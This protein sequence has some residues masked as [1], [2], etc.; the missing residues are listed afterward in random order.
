MTRIGHDCHDFAT[1][2][3]LLNELRLKS[4]DLL[5]L[6]WRTRDVGGSEL[7]TWLRD[8]FGNRIPLLL[9]ATE[10]DKPAL[11]RSL[12]NGAD[13]FLLRPLCRIELQARVQALL[14]RAYPMRF[15]KTLDCGP[16]HF[17]PL[18]RTLLLRGKAIKLK[19]REYDLALYLCRNAG[20]LMTRENLIHTVWGQDVEDH[21]R[22]IDTH[23]SR[24]R[25]RMDLCPENGVVLTSVYGLGYR[26]EVCS[27][28]EHNDSPYPTA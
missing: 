9:V 11:L 15:E 27:Q 17:D 12:V 2:E 19:H 14:R 25:T 8:R 22:S 28:A 26:L 20:R 21:S 3:S 5:L 13:D 4:Y 18:T 24:V 10:R 7:V 16:Y 1:G 6:D 23:V